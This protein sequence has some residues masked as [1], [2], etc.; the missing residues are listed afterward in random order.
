MTPY[1]IYFWELSL[2][3]IFFGIL[4]QITIEKSILSQ[5]NDWIL[6]EIVA[7]R[8]RNSISMS[9][10]ILWCA[11]EQSKTL[12]IWFWTI[13]SETDQIL[14][15]SG[16]GIFKAHLPSD[17]TI[18]ICNEQ[19][20]FWVLETACKMTLECWETPCVIL[21]TH[22]I[23]FISIS[24]HFWSE[25]KNRFLVVSGFEP[26][27]NPKIWK[28][29]EVRGWWGTLDIEFSQKIAF[30][31]RTRPEYFFCKKSEDFS[32]RIEKVVI[33]KKM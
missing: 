8:L 21:L 18:Q 24:V 23:E 6:S 27:K 9:T 26:K 19:T 12:K 3:W 17:V 22:F 10:T 33:K 28:F 32:S 1:P 4:T 30:L 29:A 7:K 31:K 15:P 5:K 11:A 14:D 16:R 13:L 20:A 25:L 2:F